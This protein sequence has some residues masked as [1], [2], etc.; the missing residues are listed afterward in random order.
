M[1]RTTLIL[2]AL[3]ASATIPATASAHAF[4]KTATP[5]VGGT[6][7]TPPKQLVIDYTEGVEPKF[8]S[9]VV[10]NA[11][12]ARMNA[13]PLKTAPG[14]DAEL[15]VPLKPLSAGTYKVTWHVTS[16]D[17]HKTQGSYTFTV[18]Q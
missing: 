7:A 13:G 14:N 8:S 16:T 1:N 4:L 9:V 3:V 18:G 2:A 5:S 6:V 17:T 10:V 12:G 11:A 15:L